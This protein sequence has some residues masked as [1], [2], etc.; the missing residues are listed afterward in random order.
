ML[1]SAGYMM[2]WQSARHGQM[3]E[4]GFSIEGGITQGIILAL[5]LCVCVSSWCSGGWTA[6]LSNSVDH[7]VARRAPRIPA[8]TAC[9]WIVLPVFAHACVWKRETRVRACVC[10][11]ER[12]KDRERE[13]KGFPASSSNSVRPDR[14][15]TQIPTQFEPPGTGQHGNCEQHSKLSPCVTYNGWRRLLRLKLHVSAPKMQ[16]AA[17]GAQCL[18][19]TDSATRPS[20]GDQRHMLVMVG[21]LHVHTSTWAACVMKDLRVHFGD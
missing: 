21:R 20:V 12:K 16:R 4:Q 19:T 9:V 6:Q 15:T 8:M 10:E 18:S 13:R 7:S 1:G 14:W 2:D 17:D 11:K 3:C 5:C